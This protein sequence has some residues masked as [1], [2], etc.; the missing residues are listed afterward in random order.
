MSNSK[1]P[2]KKPELN[3]NTY[4]DMYA[5][6]LQLDPALIA[7][8]K[9]QGL[10]PKWL[11]AKK[12]RED[13]FHRTGFRPY[14]RKSAGGVA[15]ELF[16]KDP[17]GFVRRKDSILGVK[18][19]EKV[20]QYRQLVRQRTLHQEDPMKNAARQIR[21]QFSEA[22]LESKVHD[23]YTDENDRSEE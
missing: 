8:L 9:E 6:P 7:E 2:L 5:N 4:M 14:K 10:T 15:E 12:I 18:E 3:Q 16:G 22:G 23:K 13:G 1:K 17:D 11:N 20:Q 19:T 21:K